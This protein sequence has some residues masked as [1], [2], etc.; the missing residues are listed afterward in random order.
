LSI[1]PKPTKGVEP[2][3]EEDVINDT[4]AESVGLLFHSYAI[5][6]ETKCTRDLSNTLFA[7]FQYKEYSESEQCIKHILNEIYRNNV[8]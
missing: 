5:S 7:T 8:T 2:V 6:M 1:R 3:E 4:R